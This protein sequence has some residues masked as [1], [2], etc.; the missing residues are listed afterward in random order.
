LSDKNR[1][2][3]SINGDKNELKPI[4]ILWLFLLSCSLILFKEIQVLKNWY[5]IVQSSGILI[6]EFVN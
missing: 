6:P 2:K 3:I 1:E 4:L 5:L